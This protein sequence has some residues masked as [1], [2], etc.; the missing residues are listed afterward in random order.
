M[1]ITKF[2]LERNETFKT[3]ANPL[4]SQYDNEVKFCPNIQIL[5]NDHL[6]FLRYCGV[7]KPKCPLGAK[8]KLANFRSDLVKVPLVV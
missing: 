3:W 5:V 6:F 4:Q 7:Q 8:E 2:F 1:G